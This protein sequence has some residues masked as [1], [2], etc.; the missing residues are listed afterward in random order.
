[1]QTTATPT[2]PA[3]ATTRAAIV[4]AMRADLGGYAAVIAHAV[5]EGKANERGYAS[6]LR[7]ALQLDAAMHEYGKDW[8]KMDDAARDEARGVY[9]ARFKKYAEKGVAVAA[10]AA[11]RGLNVTALHDLS[12]TDAIKAVVAWLTGHCGV[13][14]IESLWTKFG[15]AGG[16]AKRAKVQAPSAPATPPAAAAAGAEPSDNTPDSPLATATGPQAYAATIAAQMQAMSDDDRA[17]FIQSLM[18]HIVDMGYDVTAKTEAEA[19]TLVT[20]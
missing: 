18:A 4:K 2:T 6:D 1:M 10:I 17:I 11:E 5:I 12:Q 14:D 13:T 16:N 9:F 7:K 3:I 15:F 20:A 8:E 19:E